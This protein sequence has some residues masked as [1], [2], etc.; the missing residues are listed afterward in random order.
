MSLPL[1]TW[2]A[3]CLLPLMT[4]AQPAASVPPL[5][6]LFL[7]NSLTEDHDLPAMVQAMA[8]LQGR[9]LTCIELTRP[10]YSLEDHWRRGSRLLEKKPCDVLVMQ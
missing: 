8:Q 3:L 1:R 10:N 7:G 4:S 9:Q 6:V 2:L 5:R